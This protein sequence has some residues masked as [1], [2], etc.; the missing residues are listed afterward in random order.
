MIDRGNLMDS[1]AG[2][3]K[4]DYD[5]AWSSQESEATTYDR[6]GRPDETSWR[7]VQKI[8]PDLEE[9]QFDGT[10]QSVRYGEP[11]P[12]RSGATW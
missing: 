8:R 2:N 12:D 7:M 9:I 6:S 11:H 10:S 5:R 4:S 3:S 1:P